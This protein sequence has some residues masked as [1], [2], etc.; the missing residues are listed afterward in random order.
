[1]KKLLLVGLLTAGAAACSTADSDPTHAAVTAYL[2]KNLND[3][4]SYEVARWGKYVRWTRQDSAG[5]AAERLEAEYD[6][7][8]GVL[9]DEQR[10]KISHS[11]IL[12]GNVTDTTRIGT[13]LTHAYRAKNKLGAT[14]LDSAQF[15]VYKNGQVQQL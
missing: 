1:M 7:S 2:Q 15:V 4:A 9:S 12:L 11:A 14:V 5:A 10:A 8:V 3:P 13:Y 6:K